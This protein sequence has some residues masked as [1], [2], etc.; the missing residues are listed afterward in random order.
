M[1]PSAVPFRVLAFAPFTPRQ[2][3]PWKEDPIRVESGDLDRTP[4]RLGISL[5]VPLP[6]DLHPQGGVT[7]AL[8]KLQDFHPDNLIEN[9]SF[10]KNLS[11]AKK[12]I[13]DARAQGLPDE[14]MFERMKA[15][16]NLPFKMPVERRKPPHVPSQHIDE[17]LKMVQL[18]EAASAPSDGAAFLIARC[19]SL[20]QRILSALFAHEDLRHLESVWRGLGFLIRQGGFNGN[21]VVDIVPISSGTIEETLDFLLRSLIRELPSLIIVDLPL[22]NAP[23]SLEVLEKVARVSETL[24]VP[25]VCWLTPKF[26][27]LDTWQNLN[28]IPF[29]PHYLAE[30]AFAKWRRFQATSSS[31]WVAA[32]CNRFLVRYPYGPDNMPKTI[33]VVEPQG[34]W[35]SPVWA[36]GCLIGRSVLKTGWPTRFTDWQTIRLEGLPLHRR[37]GNKQLATETA[38]SDERIDQFIRAGITPLV[39]PYDKD[40]AFIPRETTVAGGSLQHQLFL[41]RISQMLF[42]CRDRLEKDLEPAVL[43]KV[44]TKM[45]SHEWEK[46]GHPVPEDLSIS[47]RKSERDELVTVRIVIEPSRRILPPGGTIEL[48]FPW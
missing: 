18:P 27:F 7:V 17:I 43:E 46:T 48:E 19:D 3:N 42:W 45:F 34:I 31:H 15:W 14:R 39:S 10:L 22:D 23:R 26:L 30:Q 9:I 25:A 21:M 16:P 12:S 36:M 29:L 8:N 38:L 37:E 5:F 24:M 40:I 2:E 32:M 28:K 33:H 11:D 44:L 35:A 4:A 47:A 1:A 41:S 20:M 13:E 6:T